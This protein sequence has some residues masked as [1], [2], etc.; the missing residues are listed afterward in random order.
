MDVSGSSWDVSR[1]IA[2]R[3]VRGYAQKGKGVPVRRLLVVW[4]EVFWKWRRFLS[5][6]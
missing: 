1:A 3:G 2:G 6:V 5:R 4:G